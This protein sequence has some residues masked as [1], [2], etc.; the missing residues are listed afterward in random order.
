MKRNEL[1][2]R[3][4]YNIWDLIKQKFTGHKYLVLWY[5]LYT[6][7]YYYNCIWDDWKDINMYPY[8]I[9]CAL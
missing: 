6:D 2:D 5:T 7:Y 4:K 3:V 1:I 9:E 8:E